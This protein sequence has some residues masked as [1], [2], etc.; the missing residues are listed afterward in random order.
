MR[1]EDVSLE[2]RVRTWTILNCDLIAVIL[3][4]HQ[5]CEYVPS[6]LKTTSVWSCTMKLSSTAT[7]NGAIEGALMV[8][9]MPYTGCSDA[10]CSWRL[11]PC[12]PKHRSCDLSPDEQLRMKTMLL[13]DGLHP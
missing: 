6:L 2:G 7:A 10:G 4:E 11:A 12:P 3:M 5:Y 13:I 1:D 8:N 9:A